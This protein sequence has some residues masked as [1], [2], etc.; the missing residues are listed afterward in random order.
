[1]SSQKV[2]PPQPVGEVNGTISLLFKINQTLIPASIL[3]LASFCMW[4]GGSIRGLESDVSHIKAD[5][6]KVESVVKENHQE[7]ERAQKDIEDDI[8]EIRKDLA[9]IK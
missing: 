2:K 4:A 5:V 3:G 8:D 9:K 1:M 6:S 7:R